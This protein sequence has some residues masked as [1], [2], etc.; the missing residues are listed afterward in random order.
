M[1]YIY[2][3]VAQL[4]LLLLQMTMTM[5]MTM[6]VMTT[7]TMTMMMLMVWW[8]WW[9]NWDIRVT[10]LNRL[11]FRIKQH[12]TCI[13]V[14]QKDEEREHKKVTNLSHVW[15]FKMI[16][17]LPNIFR[18]TTGW[19]C[20]CTA[21]FILYLTWEI[22]WTGRWCSSTNYDVSMSLL[23][24]VHFCLTFVNFKIALDQ[25]LS[26]N[27]FAPIMLFLFHIFV[28]SVLSHL[29]QPQLESH[30]WVVFEVLAKTQHVW[31]L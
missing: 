15:K 12:A 4:N 22:P 27:N 18:L 7:T 23:C 24:T 1:T 11:S 16:P 8:W 17:L 2:K 9:V 3:V 5:T 29:L 10:Q 21:N 14:Q 26:W 28:S 30:L 25:S 13:F 6:V 31:V 19:V 20:L